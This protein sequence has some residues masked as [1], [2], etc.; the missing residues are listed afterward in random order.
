MLRRIQ[1][2]GA[3]A[4]LF[5]LLVL[6]AWLVWD[7]STLLWHGRRAVGMRPATAASFVA[8]SSTVQFHVSPAGR[9]TI[10]E[11]GGPAPYFPLRTGGTDFARLSLEPSVTGLWAPTV[12]HYDSRVEMM[13]LH[14]YPPGQAPAALRDELAARLASSPAWDRSNPMPLLLKHEPRS[15]IEVPI[16][17]GYVHNAGAL[18]V[19]AALAWSLGWVPRLAAARIRERRR[20]AGLC[21]FCRYDMHGLATAMC[22]ECGKPSS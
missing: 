1:R 14:G 8:R 21:P 7:T 18:L 20:A 16:P 11:D 3:S 4:A 17:L 22:P 10:P 13:P 2:P 19:L 9:Y 5:I 6:D 15:N 12:R